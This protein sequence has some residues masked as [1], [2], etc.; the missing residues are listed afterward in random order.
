MLNVNSLLIS[1]L[2]HSDPFRS[3]LGQ[4]TPPLE[5]TPLTGA[6]ITASS[7]PW[8]L[9]IVFVIA[10]FLIGYFKKN[11]PNKITNTSCVPLID[12]DQQ[13]REKSRFSGDET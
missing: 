8:G 12:E 13:A 5:P 9:V 6:E 4:G 7:F 3:I 10:G 2:I 1:F 11:N